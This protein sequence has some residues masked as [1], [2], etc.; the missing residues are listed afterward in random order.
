MYS[1]LVIVRLTMRGLFELVRI[2]TDR[3]VQLRLVLSIDYERWEGTLLLCGHWFCMFVESCFVA[4][5]FNVLV[6]AR[7]MIVFDFVKF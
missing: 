7:K 4:A 3:R 6:V 1:I 2:C 5:D